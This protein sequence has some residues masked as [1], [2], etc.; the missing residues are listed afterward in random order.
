MA[1]TSNPVTLLLVAWSHGEEKALDELMP[2]VY[3][4]LKRIARSLFRR[5]RSAI[6]LQPTALVHEAYL[7]LIDQR[8][9]EWRDRANFFAL[10]ATLM[11]R[12]LVDHARRKSAW[13][14]GRGAQLVTLSEAMEIR[15]EN[16]PDVLALDEAL[17]ALSVA[18]PEQS[19][20]VELR[21]FGG[22]SIDE[23][24]QALRI[25]P[26]TVKR[27]WSTAR[28]WLRRKLNSK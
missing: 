23:T 11:R 26:A 10:S 15:S 2:L 5:E 6:T 17:N 13:K 20:I 21:F 1:P 12:I 3:A 7:K 25:S 19:R 22:L 28:L 14:R 27:D 4:E 24:A 16:P 18:D 8:R 9:V